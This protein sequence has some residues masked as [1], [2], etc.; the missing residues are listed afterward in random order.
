[1]RNFSRALL[2]SSAA[3]EQ[4]R[5]RLVPKTACVARRTRQP[6]LAP[7]ARGARALN[8]LISSALA[9]RCDGHASMFFAC[10]E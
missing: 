8:G 1:M 10:P 5:D 4:V 2:A 6:D 3:H 7:S 9:S